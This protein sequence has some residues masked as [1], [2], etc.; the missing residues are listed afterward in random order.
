MVQGILAISL[1]I[2][3]LEIINFT[4]LDVKDDSVLYKPTM[5]VAPAC[6]DY[7]V[8]RLLG[9]KSFLEELQLGLSQIEGIKKR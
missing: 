7:T 1:V 9:K 5:N 8:G 2:I 3:M 6:Y 4:T